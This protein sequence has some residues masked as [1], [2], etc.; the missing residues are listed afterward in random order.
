MVEYWSKIEL[1][2]C[3]FCDPSWQRLSVCGLHL[4]LSSKLR[5]EY[6]HAAHLEPCPRGLYRSTS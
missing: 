4:L 5:A 2:L 1:E 6:G 3:E